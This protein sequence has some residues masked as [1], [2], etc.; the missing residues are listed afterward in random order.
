MIDLHIHLLPGIDDGAADLAEAVGMCRLSAESGCEALIATPHQRVE[1]WWNDD[2]DVL[3]RLRREVRE[4]IGPKP[5]VYSG[6]EIRIDTELLDDLDDMGSSGLL[7]LAGSRY[8]LLEF[9]R[10]GRGP[11]PE[12]FVHEVIL[13][14]WRPILAHPELVPSLSGNPE[15]LR[16]LVELGA[17]LQVTAMSLTGGFGPKIEKIAKKMV[18]AGLVEFVASDA[19]GTDWRPPG[20]LQAFRTIAATW[21]TDL[22]QS[23]TTSN[24]LAVLE[25][26]ALGDGSQTTGTGTASETLGWRL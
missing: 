13:S 4:A 17:H 23:L 9:D 22:A 7:P 10:Q 6:A 14:G 25:D 12:S 21:G 20:L 11:E 5:R 8:L 3:A 18:D 16:R 24:P 15:L 26:R 1:R 19:H 2:L